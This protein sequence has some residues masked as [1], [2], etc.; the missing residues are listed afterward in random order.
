MLLLFSI[1]IV[2]QKNIL[3]YTCV[4]SFYCT[5]EEV[6]VKIIKILIFKKKNHANIIVM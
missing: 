1:L 2:T 5:I 4:Y 6:N 3:L